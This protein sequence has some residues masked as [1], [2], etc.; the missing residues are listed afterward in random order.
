MSRSTLDTRSEEPGASLPHRRHL[1]RW[2][3][4]GIALVMAVV[5]GV[6]ATRRPAA[7]VEANTP[8]LGKP[9]PEIAGRS[10]EGTKVNLASLKGHFV[11]V[12]FFAS[13]CE[14]CAEEAPHLVA[15]AYAHKSGPEAV[16][17]IGVPF[18]DPPSAV[19][20]FMRSTGAFWP[21]VPDPSGK[22]ALEYGVRGPPETFVIAPDG[23]IIAHYDGPVTGRQL[24]ALLA[25]A[26]RAGL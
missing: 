4:L 24:D 22:L 16:S 1:A 5:V 14:P 2:I 12:N 3:A 26:R 10:L 17:L 8:L 13:W 19:L 15:W 21:V 25:Q 9:A 11:V 6:L 23:R 20:G 18:D 7:V